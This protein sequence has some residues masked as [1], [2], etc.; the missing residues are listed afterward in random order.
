M[1][2]L[3]WTIELDGTTGDRTCIENDIQCWESDAFTTMPF[4]FFEWLHSPFK[5]L[6]QIRKSK[7]EEMV[8]YD[9]LTINMSNLPPSQKQHISKAYVFSTK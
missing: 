7:Y 4:S 8:L 5:N 1:L 3:T 6:A 2:P 9:R